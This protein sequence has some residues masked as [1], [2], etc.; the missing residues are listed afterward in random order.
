MRVVLQSVEHGR[1]IAEDPLHVE[2]TTPLF[3]AREIHQARMEGWD[4]HP[5]ETRLQ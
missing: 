4:I 2:I 5:W 1:P 3:L